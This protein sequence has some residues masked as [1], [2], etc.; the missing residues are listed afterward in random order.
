MGWKSPVGIFPCSNMIKVSA[1]K[2]LTSNFSQHMCQ[3]SACLTLWNTS[4]IKP[5]NFTYDTQ[6]KI[7]KRM[8]IKLMILKKSTSEV[9]IFLYLIKFQEGF[10]MSGRA[11]VWGAPSRNNS[12]GGGF[13]NLEHEITKAWRKLGQEDT[14]EGVTVK[15]WWMSR[16]LALRL[17][18]QVPEDSV[19]E[20]GGPRTSGTGTK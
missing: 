17:K 18:T 12:R 7:M 5:S 13:S 19:S 8:P 1:W 20:G 3:R 16:R 10:K 9:S 2:Y 6:S 11:E 15:T 14:E 4:K